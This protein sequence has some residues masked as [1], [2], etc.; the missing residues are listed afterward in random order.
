L[1]G[2][3]AASPGAFTRVRV[4]G[5]FTAGQLEDLV[6]DDGGSVWPS[7]DTPIDF[8]TTFAALETL[9]S[10]GLILFVPLGF[11]PGAVS[12]SPVVPPSDWLAWKQLV[13]A[14]L[15][16][17][18]A[19]PRFGADA[20]ANWWLEVWNEPNEDRFWHGNTD[21]YLALYQATSE[22]V[23][24]SGMTI[25]LGGPAIAFKPQV[26]PAQGAP[27]LERFL[28]FIAADRALHY[29]FV[30]FHRKGTVGSDLLDPRRL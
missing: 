11:S 6:P 14:F 23:T 5:A 13:I 17:L 25:R 21:D 29:D 15:Q 18:A 4:F 12:P 8:A 9:T 20:I 19:D 16:Q 3:L 2:N 26:D 22:A 10:R 1:L 27:W 7:P 30:S 24:T 28:R